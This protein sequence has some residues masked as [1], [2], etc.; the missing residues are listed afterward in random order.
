MGAPGFNNPANLQPAWGKGTRLSRRSGHVD[1]A[2]RAARKLTPKA[3]TFC[4][5]VLDDEDLDIR[6][7]I[8]A[9]E[10][11]LLHG[12]PKGDAHR[13]HLEA[14]EGSAVNSLRVEFVAA[15]GSTVSFEQAN[16]PQIVDASMDKTVIDHTALSNTAPLEPISGE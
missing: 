9:A 8:K 7:R 13:R 14:I 16:L 11:I 5:R 1:K 4:A 2:L 10:I 15:D 12:M 3:I 6:Y